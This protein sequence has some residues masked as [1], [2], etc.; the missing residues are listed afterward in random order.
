M[1]K[2]EQ[3]FKQ[4]KQHLSELPLLVVPKLK[5]EMIVYMS[6]SH[7]AISAV[8]MTERGMVQTPVYFVSRAL[9]GPELNYT[10]ME[11][12]ILSL[13]FAAKRLRRYF[14][15]HPIVVITDQPIKQ[16]MSRP[17][18][19]GRSQ[20]WSVMQGEHNITYRPRTS[21]KGQILM[22][23]LMEKPDEGQPNTPMV[24]TLQGSWT[25]FTNGSS[26][27]DGS[28]TR[29]ILTSPKGT[30]FTYSLRFQSTTS[31]NEA[32]Y[33]ALIAGL[34]I[35]AQIGVCNV[36]MTPIMEYLKD[37]TLPGDRKEASK[38][39][40]KDRQYELVKGVLYRQSF[41]KPWLSDNPFKD[42]CD[43]LN[44]TQRF[45]SVKHS[46]SNG[47]VERANWSLGKGIKACLREGNKNWIEELPHVL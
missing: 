38:L 14:Q 23:F 12:L 22:D 10:Q 7:R 27:V 39:R 41:L 16:I 19:V 40:I 42:W 37:G 47:L 5:E 28:G 20:K 33:E 2:A 8:L 36:H 45:A 43:K 24:G 9:Q 32:E 31:N 25:L 44:I 11:K 1:P 4:L 6:T 30:E 3:P 34:R 26:C 13:V 21:V 29:L 15:V 35:A 18:V 46:Q 17:D